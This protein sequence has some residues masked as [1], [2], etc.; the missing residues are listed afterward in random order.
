MKTRIIS[1]IM[2][3]IILFPIL[4]IGGTLFDIMMI[5]MAM[6][7]LYELFNMRAH[8]KEIP[9]AVKIISFT[10]LFLFITSGSG[11]S[12]LSFS[13]EYKYVVAFILTLL[14]PIIIYRNK[15][16][17]TIE[18]AAYTITSVLLLGVVFNLIIALR[19]VRLAY[20]IY[21]LIIS[22]SV[23]SFGILAGS[24]IGRHKL[25][26]DISPKKTI[27]GAVYGFFM[28]TILASAFFSII[29][30]NNVAPLLIILMSAV[31]SVAAIIGDLFFSAIKRQ[32]KEK[33]FSN[34]IPGHGGILDRIDSLIFVLLAFVLFASIL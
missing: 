16:D 33:D 10:L 22:V 17:Y 26:L 13:F 1:A 7:A 31:L 28:A 25:A 6:G 9:F 34:L 32:Y 5:T 29:I 8:V 4:L 24:L 14:L 15:E 27:E 21:L 3:I 12:G 19:D 2:M 23:D 30:S 18:D 20:I 11:H